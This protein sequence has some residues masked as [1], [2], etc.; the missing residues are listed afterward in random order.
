M[1]Q[2]GLSESTIDAV[3]KE[4]NDLS[5]RDIKQLL[6]LG[7]LWAAREEKPVDTEV[8]SFVKAFLPARSD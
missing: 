3:L 6:K 1:N 2:V 5:G 8:I 7:A 4:N